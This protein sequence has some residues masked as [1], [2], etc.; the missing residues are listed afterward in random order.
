MAKFPK[1]IVDENA[2]KVF[3]APT[4]NPA[5]IHANDETEVKPEFREL[6]TGEKGE[7]YMAKVKFGR[8]SW[9]LIE[10]SASMEEE[11][12][13]EEVKEPEE[14]VNATTEEPKKTTRRTRK[15]TTRKTATKKA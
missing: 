11:V 10:E 14:P 3:K 13:A 4:K 15:T 7:V 8:V 2:L 1:L 5:P 12:E 6:R 9:F